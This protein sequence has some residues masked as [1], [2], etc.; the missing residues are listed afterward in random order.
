MDVLGVGGE[1]Q[2]RRD[3]GK[4]LVL[5]TGDDVHGAEQLGFLDRFFRPGAGVDVVGL[6]ADEQVHGDHA[7]LQAGAALQ[8]HHAVVFRHAEQAADLG[9][10]AIDHGLEVLG[11]V[12]D[13]HDRQPDAVEVQQFRLRLFHH[14][15]G[16]DRR[17]G[18]EII[19]FG[20]ICNPP[21]FF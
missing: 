18:I 21:C 3:I 19:L 5:G 2:V 15:L 6:L 16:Q 9:F 12:A 4:I 13:L 14:F 8:E 11:A 17:T 7:E 20:H 10:G 1:L